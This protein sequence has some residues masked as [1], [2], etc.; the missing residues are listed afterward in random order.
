VAT[1]NATYTLGSGAIDGRVT[2]TLDRLDVLAHGV[3]PAWRPAGAVSFDVQLGGTA[4][5]PRVVGQFTASD[6]EIASQRVVS[7]AGGIRLENDV[8][9]IDSLNVTQPGGGALSG[10]FAYNLESSA[11]EAMLDG[12]QIAL[13]TL[14]AGAVTDAPLE[15]SALF[16]LQLDVKGTRADPAG[17]GRLSFS[18]LRVGTTDLGTPAADLSFHDGAAWIDGTIEQLALAVEGR[19]SLLAPYE[20]RIT[21][22]FTDTSVAQLAGLATAIPP[23]VTGTTSFSVTA[24]GALASWREM[25]FEGTVSSLDARID[26]RAIVLLQP[27]RFRY[28]DDEIT[29]E[30]LE[31]GSGEARVGVSGTLSRRDA[32]GRLTASVAG[33]LDDLMPFARLAGAPDSVSARGLVDAR[34]DLSGSLARPVVGGTFSLENADLIWSSFSAAGVTARGALQDGVLRMETM[35]GYWQGASFTG[36][37]VFPLVVLD[38]RLPDAIVATLPPSPREASFN[39]RVENLTAASVSPWLPPDTAAQLDGRMTLTIEARTDRLELA[40]LTG[41]MLVEDAVVSF[42]RVPIVQ[43]LP[44]RITFANGDVI[45]EATR[46]SGAGTVLVAS[47]KAALTPET[48]VIDA[49]AYGSVDLR[50]FSAFSNN[51]ATGG[52]AE[53]NLR[54]QGPWNEPQVTGRLDLQGAEIRVRE[55]RV[56]LAELSGVVTLA[57]NRVVFDGLRGL[58]NGGDIE[59]RGALSHEGLSLV[60]GKVDIQARHVG[61]DYPEGLRSLFDSSLVLTVADGGQAVLSGMVTIQRGAYRRR[62]SLTRELLNTTGSTIVDTG[63]EPTIFGSTRLNIAV[64]TAEDV[65]VDNN[66]AR[67]ELEA[68]LRLTGTIDKPAL[69]G[70]ATIREGGEIHLGGNTYLIDRGT[71][72]FLNPNVITPTLDISARTRVSRYDITM[73]V[74]GAPGSI[75]TDF[76]SDP[77]LGQDDVVSLLLTGR[78]MEQAGSAQADVAQEQLLGLLSGEFLSAAGGAVGLDRLRF[79]RGLS[80]DVARVDP[81]Y[82]ATETDPAARLTIAKYLS[83]EVELIVSRNL[84]TG[85]ITWIVGYQPTRRIEIRTITRDNNDRSYEFSQDM[86]FGGPPRAERVGRPEE[87]RRVS[88]IRFSGSPGF[89]EPELMNR[90]RLEVGDRFDFYDWQD[91]QDRLLELYHDRGFY[92]ARVTARRSTEDLPPDQIRLEYNLVRGPATRLTVEGATLP[93]GVQDDIRDAWTRSV[94]DEFLLDD[95]RTLTRRWLVDDGYLRSVVD[96]RVEQPGADEK[97]IAVRIDRGPQSSDREIVFTGNDAIEAATIRDFVRARQVEDSAWIDPDGLRQAVVDLYRSRGWLAAEARVDDPQ[98]DGSRAALPVSISE[99]TRFTVAS[100]QLVGVLPEREQDVRGALGVQVGQPYDPTAVDVGRATV[101]ARYRRQGFGSVATST[102]TAVNRETATVDL[103]LNVTE[104]VRQVIASVNVLGANRTNRS[105]LT[106]A[107]KLTVGSPVSQSEWYAARKRLYDTGVFRRVDIDAVPLET[108]PSIGGDGVIEERVEARVTVEE[109]ATTRFRYG[110]QVND[111]RAPATDTRELGPGFTT[112]LER[113]NLFGRA[114]KAGIAFRYD[115]TN[116]IGRTYFV[117]PRFFGWPITS[118]IFLSRARERF[119]EADFNPFVT[120]RWELTAEQRFRPRSR[121]EVAYSYQFERSRTFDPQPDPLDPFPLDIR[122]LVARL[123]STTTIDTRDDPFSATTGWFH[124]SSVEYAP[125][126][127]G[128]DLRFIKVFTQQYYYR[129]LG[130]RLVFA[131][132]ARLGIAD[133]LGQELIPSERF[134][135]GGGN[136]VRGYREDSLGGLDA[137]GDPIG[138]DA[139]LEL[140][141]ELRFPVYGWLAGVG[142]VDAGNVFP[143]PSDISFA[144]LK[145]GIGVGM[146][147]DTPIALI[148]LDFGVPLSEDARGEKKGRWFLSIGQSF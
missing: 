147:L 43:E 110:L 122:V 48:P 12:R 132:A 84:R 87:R 51:V 92:E 17:S 104:G 41:T 124:S 126:I 49:E 103:T 89:P 32:T 13:G 141:E 85:D 139:L 4:T 54:A 38:D 45:V 59:I 143:G 66:Y 72:D 24:T 127:L 73:N 27:G 9:T 25:D 22:E 88:A 94:F 120:D 135:A 69:G 8:L 97:I 26:D 65:V 80:E 5:R 117:I 99:G 55:P 131:T 44:T 3:P 81:G 101:D 60:G 40:G 115:R 129:R 23:A 70:R 16:D 61:L 86:S 42:S 21:A 142:F 144:A 107:L 19:V 2:G 128:S 74:S 105:F 106:S 116:R 10:S 34:I 111:E 123:N 93:G 14:P 83:P 146:R 67:L 100:V 145:V 96:P 36:S 28:V 95:V 39:L 102:T 76:V 62:L 140:N 64:V 20:S 134:F 137:F 71:I 118:S 79:E 18:S 68:D 108:T 57:E 29:A 90:L 63:A 78:T 114:A 82:V 47:G 46:L 91:D 130:T 30:G 50:L 37:G 119:G 112:N 125:E 113:F 31:L 121:M 58:A 35:S 75:Q 52:L 133:G 109:V 136:S 138:G 77:P 98:F 148:R 33:P 53:V 56:A 15:L 11:L 7:A 6:L 1:V